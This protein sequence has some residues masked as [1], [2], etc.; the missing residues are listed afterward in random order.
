MSTSSKPRILNPARAS[1]VK[2]TVSTAIMLASIIGLAVLG[3]FAVEEGRNPPDI[4]DLPVISANPAPFKIQPKDPGGMQIPHQEKLVFNRF[5]AGKEEEIKQER[6]NIMPPPEEPVSREIILREVGNTV[7]VMPENTMDAEGEMSEE[8]D[9]AVNNGDA[10]PEE[11]LPETTTAAPEPIENM[12]VKVQPD[13]DARLLRKNG[14]NIVMLPYIADTPAVKRFGT[15]PE[16]IQPAP[17]KLDIAGAD[18]V[19]KNVATGKY[20]LQLGAYREKQ[21]L[22]AGW[23]SMQRRF[24]ESLGSLQSQVKM[25]NIPGKGVFYRLYAGPLD[26]QTAATALCASLKAKRQGCLVKS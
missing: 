5:S 22:R 1:Y 21:V 3:W 25:V 7:D 24:P 20:W 17:L 23:E 4:A 6:S 10:S 26:S 14:V 11:I 19:R 18:A 2:R 15:V 12:T 9:A 8:M 13:V 16:G